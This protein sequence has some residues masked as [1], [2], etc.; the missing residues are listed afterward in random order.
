MG[1]RFLEG[2]TLSRLLRLKKSLGLSQTPARPS[3]EPST[4]DESGDLDS[5]ARAT[6]D[7]LD[8]SGCLCVNCGYNQRGVRLQRCPECGLP[9]AAHY[10]D[11]TPWGAASP[12]AGTWWATARKVWTWDRRVRV[13]TSLIPRTAVA[14]RFALWAI[15]LTTLMASTASALG[16]TPTKSVKMLFA[17]QVAIHFIQGLIIIGLFLLGVLFGLAQAMKSIWRRHYPFVPSSIYYATA[18]WTLTACLFLL[19]TGLSPLFAAYD[20]PD[21][22]VIPC[23]VGLVPWGLWLGASL[24]EA[25]C[26]S[27]PTL[28]FGSTILASLVVGGVVWLGIPGTAQFTVKQIMALRES[29]LTRAQTFGSVQAGLPRA[30]QQ[31]YALIIDAIQS[32]DADLALRGTEKLGA[33]QATR[34]LVRGNAATMENIRCSLASLRGDV[35]LKDRVVLY[36]HGHGAKDGAGAIQM[37]DGFVTS[38][39]IADFVKDL[40]TPHVLVIIDSCFGGKF[41]QAVRASGHA[42]VVLTS[43]DNQNVSYQDGLRPFW[44]VLLQPQPSADGDGDGRVTVSEAFWSVYS[45]MLKEGE[46]TRTKWAT[47]KPETDWMLAEFGYSTPQLDVLGNASEGDF[48]VQIPTSSLEDGKK[49]ATQD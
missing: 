38:Q 11:P 29:G 21:L 23:L 18:W 48:Y 7:D 33:D 17:A 26:A 2:G 22:T 39:M 31:T 40:P 27:R 14:R 16:H 32:A 34:V 30:T 28:R 15:L 4:F 46:V 43:T 47:Y 36:I 6:K 35:K 19:I 20:L 42:A 8:S 10:F 44:T 37:R 25:E 13:R 9:L 45:N 49:P 24:S 5:E 41:V 12:T 1:F 3:A